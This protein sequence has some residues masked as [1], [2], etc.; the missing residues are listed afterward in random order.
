M[1]GPL[2]LNQLLMPGICPRVGGKGVISQA[3]LPA[4][5]TNMLFIQQSFVH[6]M[7]NFLSSVLFSSS[8]S[9]FENSKFC[10]GHEL[11]PGSPWCLCRIVT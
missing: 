2:V 5:A 3:S 11:N 6:S 4:I 9:K 10:L 8:G 7:V 1:Q